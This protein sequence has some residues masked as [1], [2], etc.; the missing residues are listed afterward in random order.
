MA[1]VILAAYLAV[2]IGLGQLEFKSTE[3][4]LKSYSSLI[5]IQS[6]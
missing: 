2:A 3:H 1:Y 5:C 6:H 4:P